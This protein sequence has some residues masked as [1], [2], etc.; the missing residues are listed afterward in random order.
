MVD[1]DSGIDEAIRAA[2]RHALPCVEMARNFL[3]VHAPVE[4]HTLGRLSAAATTKGVRIG[5]LDRSLYEDPR[6]AKAFVS[7]YR[8]MSQDFTHQYDRDLADATAQTSRR[9]QQACE[10]CVQKLLSTPALTEWTIEIDGL[11]WDLYFHASVTRT[12]FENFLRTE[13]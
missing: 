12:D 8:K 5:L 3:L 10:R 4:D 11:A 13:A 7:V 6:M 1:F 2:A 9:L